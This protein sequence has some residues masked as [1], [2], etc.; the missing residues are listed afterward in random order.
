VFPVSFSVLAFRFFYVALLE[1]VGEAPSTGTDAGDIPPAS[2]P[3][4][5]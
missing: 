5:A 1:C 4:P 2:E 3:P